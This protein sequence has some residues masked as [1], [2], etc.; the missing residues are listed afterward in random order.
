MEATKNINFAHHLHSQKA[1][2][3]STAIRRPTLSLR[4]FVLI[5]CHARLAYAAC[6]YGYTQGAAY[7]NV[8]VLA[9][10][11]NTPSQ[12]KV[13]CMQ[14]YNISSCVTSHRVQRGPRAA[15]DLTRNSAGVSGK[16]HH[17]SILFEVG[18]QR[19]DSVCS[20]D[21]CGATLA[22]GSSVG[23]WICSGASNQRW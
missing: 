5:T 16:E 2:H 21:I 4:G 1:L 15:G 23:S 22:A 7:G 18:I 19:P 12:C 11:T 17:K 6:P 14:S 13:Q 10:C 9:N 3:S 8:L 20:L